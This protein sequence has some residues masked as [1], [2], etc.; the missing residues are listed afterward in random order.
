MRRRARKR[1]GARARKRRNAC[2]LT[3]GA[4]QICINHEDRTTGRTKRLALV[5]NLHPRSAI[6][7]SAAAPGLSS[8]ETRTGC[9]RSGEPP[10]EGGGGW[11]RRRK[12]VIS[13]WEIRG[14]DALVSRDIPTSLREIADRPDRSIFKRHSRRIRFK[15]PIALKP[16]RSIRRINSRVFNKLIARARVFLRECRS[17][18]RIVRERRLRYVV[19]RTSRRVNSEFQRRVVRS[20]RHNPRVSTV[21]RTREFRM[22]GRDWARKSRKR[23]IAAGNH[24]LRESDCVCV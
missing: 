22:L 21:A 17:P 19:Y 3:A 9:G 10:K 15:W 14:I 8:N 23:I 5:E 16:I 6:T 11:G 18:D 20:A 4:N 12:R 2:A 7:A 1:V 24:R 13:L